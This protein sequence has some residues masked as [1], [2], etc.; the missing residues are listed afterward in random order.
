MHS[1]IQYRDRSTGEICQEKVYGAEFLALLYGGSLLAKLIGQPLEWAASHFAAPSRLYGW[2]QNRPRSKNKVA[3]FI[4]EYQLDPLEFVKRVDHF[5]SFNDFFIRKLKPSA[6]PI[7]SDSA[8]LVA[9]ADGRY[10]ATSAIDQAEGF[11]VKGKRF[12]LASLLRDEKLADHYSGGAMVI[13]RLCPSDYHRFHFPCSGVAGEAVEI[14]GTLYSVNPAAT[15]RRM[16]IFAENK[17]VVTPFESDFFGPILIIEVGATCVGT[18][19]QTYTP[20]KR[21]EKGEE[22]G[23]F[24]FGGSSLILL[25][26]PGRLVLASDLLNSSDGFVELLCKMGQPIARLA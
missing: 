25:F 2:L 9:P 23:Y 13:A 8:T 3:P 26:E 6:R 12:C 21:V 17:R 4:Q 15:R 19:H 24:S 22:K 14:P 20:H 5:T 18:I 10:W 16:G 11:L 1:P 7:D